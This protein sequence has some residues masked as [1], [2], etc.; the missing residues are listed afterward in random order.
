MMAIALH[1]YDG[2]RTGEQQR[3]SDGVVPYSN[4][5]NNGIE[6]EEEGCRSNTRPVS[7]PHAPVR[8]RGCRHTEEGITI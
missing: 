4:T 8:W 5:A 1:R 3:P 2:Q 6:H 7:S